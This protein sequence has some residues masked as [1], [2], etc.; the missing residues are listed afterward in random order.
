MIKKDRDSVR[1]PPELLNRLVKTYFNGSEFFDPTP[2]VK[3]FDERKHQCGLALEWTQ[4]FVYCNPPYS[5]SKNFIEK[6]A[7]ES[8]KH[9]NKIMM[10]IKLTCLSSKYFEKIMPLVK[11]KNFNERIKFPGYDNKARFD[12]CLLFFNFPEEPKLEIISLK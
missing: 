11:V 4:Q 1:T 10:L 5:K 8:L 2:Y 9:G 12:S 3:N 6:S 7:L